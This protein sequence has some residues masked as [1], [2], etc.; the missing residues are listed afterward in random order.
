MPRTGPL[1]GRA[2]TP[3]ALAIA[4][5]VAI[6]CLGL[7]AAPLPAASPSASSPAAPSLAARVG[8]EAGRWL[9]RSFGTR[10]LERL[11]AGELGPQVFAVA[12]SP[13]GL[14]YLANN[15]GVVEL[16]GHRS[17][18]LRVQPGR[19]ALS[20]AFDAAGRLW[21]GGSGVFGRL[22]PGA[23]GDLHFVSWLDRLA[24]E[25]RAFTDVWTAVAAP[26]GVVL[27]APERL[28]LVQGETVKAFRPEGIFGT[29]G[30]LVNGRFFQRDT[31]AGLLELRAD[32]LHAVPGGEHFAKTRAFV[33]LPAADGRLLVGTREEGF[34]I[35]DPDGPLTTPLVR[36]PTAIDGLL[37]EA[38][39][40]TGV[41]LGDGTYAI[42]TLRRGAFVLDRDGRLRRR[43]DRA[44]GLV[45]DNVLAL[46]A[47]AAG[48][49]WL[50]QGRGLSRVDHP[51]LSRFAEDTGLPGSVE[52]LA[53]YA[54][55]LY[56]ATSQGVYRLVP[57][58]AANEEAH[59]ELVPGLGA[60]AFDLLATDRS[61]L[62]GTINGTFEL[63]ATG[64]SQLSTTQTNRLL[65]L[66]PAGGEVLLATLNGLAA[67]V[68]EGGAWRLLE[69]ATEIAGEV[70]DLRV[71]QGELFATTP[72]GTDL[73]HR[74]AV[75][76]LGGAGPRLVLG[77]VRTA[78]AEAGLTDFAT[79]LALGDRV[80]I[81][82]A[83]HVLTPGE[84]G[85]WVRDEALETCLG[86][87]AADLSRLVT[88]GPG[89]FLVGAGRRVLL[90]RE[91][92]GR[93]LVSPAIPGFPEAGRVLALYPEPPGTLWVGTDE[94][95]FRF[96]PQAEA[97]AP[98]PRA[99]RVR[100][101]AGPRGDVLWW[102][103]PASLVAAQGLPAPLPATARALRVEVAIPWDDQPQRARFRSRLLPLEAEPSSWSAVPWREFTN[104]PSGDFRLELE[105]L[106]A[107]GE[108]LA[109]T[110]LA[111]RILPFW[112]ETWWARAAFVLALAGL[113]LAFARWRS[114]Q[115]RRRN[116][117]LEALVTQ[118]TEELREASFTDP[119]TAARNRRYFT[120]SIEPELARAA[121]AGGEDLVFLLIDL[122]HFKQ[123]NDRWGHATGD[124][125]LRQ[126]ADRLRA[127]MRPS[128]LLFRWGGE[129][130]LL[131]ARDLPR[132]RAED[133]AGRVLGAIAGSAFAR[134][135]GEPLAVTASVGWAPF[136][137][138][139]E[140]PSGASV[141]A[142]LELADRGLY[143]AKA[144]GRACAVG[145]LPLAAGSEP[146]ATLEPGFGEL[147]FERRLS[148]MSTPRRQFS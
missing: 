33:F 68:R 95:L 147:R 120:A 63:A 25:D 76:R 146:P 84:G 59:L 9:V 48:T 127:T 23:D 91:E 56:A 80:V 123:I 132:E 21:V 87:A 66:D 3:V 17:R 145:L 8:D 114:A 10:D 82:T 73:L 137:L 43:L 139:R 37:A 130:F 140:Q 44:R 121:R 31:A 136:P 14:T 134:A 85:Q 61:L 67:L 113:G 74:T 131:V 97:A 100:D 107:E 122:D 15:Y 42:G 75:P 50:G 142:V 125:V 138:D 39:L 92:A 34:W 116:L 26:F 81:G 89:R 99:V 35:V 108:A 32:G 88:I 36:W 133:V 1:P 110:S 5:V 112:W 2:A 101:L 141:A 45:D 38:Q 94:G 79:P 64:L 62:A 29:S 129:E 93:L 117:Q 111:F 47:D 144:A 96:D 53:R 78:G 19:I 109:P 69:P 30:G 128:D 27:R 124:A 18:L 22:E 65:A 13:T 16:D 143:A 28:F 115:L 90:L 60:Q 105:A 57:A 102:A 83:G 52:S 4:I 77:A 46:T 55:S 6:L 72:F 104:L 20:L 135:G 71:G 103:D 51:G 40:Y 98:A 58:S 7:C 54:G 70:S 12:R 148:R 118:R 119:L 106:G 86:P 49:L 41:A 11:G 126:A 24:P